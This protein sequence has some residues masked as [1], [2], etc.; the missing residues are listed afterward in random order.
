MSIDRTDNHHKEEPN[1]SGSATA[2]P[3]PAAGRWVLD[4]HRTCIAT[5]TRAM[6]G[7]FP[8]TGRFRLKAGEIVIGTEPAA[9]SVTATVDAKTFES[10]NARRDAD[11]VSAALLDAECHS[12]IVFTSSL[13]QGDGDRWVVTGELTIHGV[14]RP[15]ELAVTTTEPEGGTARISAAARLDRRQFN[16]TGK[17][18]L[19]GNKVSLVIDAIA[20]YELSTTTAQQRATRQAPPRVDDL[21]ED[22][23]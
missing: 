12:D 9:C 2:P 23:H 21:A 4:P 16:I 18:G 22:L 13:V 11:V 14:T 6:F 19:V 7:L 20:Q 8:V 5:R 17:R 15:L 1:V 10:G 3:L